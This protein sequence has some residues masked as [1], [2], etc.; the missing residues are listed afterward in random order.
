MLNVNYSPVN[1]PVPKGIG[2]LLGQ[3]PS[4]QGDQR[5]VSTVRPSRAIRPPE[6]Q[7]QRDQSSTADHRKVGKTSARRMRT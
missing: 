5:L 1:Y 6:L 3:G 7:G 4:H 2:R